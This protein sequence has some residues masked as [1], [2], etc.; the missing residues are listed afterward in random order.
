M[1][2]RFQ[3]LL[4]WQKA[5]AL[6]LDVYR[7]TGQFPKQEQFGLVSQRSRAAVSV[8]SNIA[9]GTERSSVKDRKHF[10]EMARTLLEELKYQCILAKDI[11]YF[12]DNEAQRLLSRAREVGKMLGG[13][14]RSL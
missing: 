7:A 10:H 6:A 9:E 13:F 12:S 2:E 11:A 14:D 3:Q 5:H 4:V 8:P 1:E